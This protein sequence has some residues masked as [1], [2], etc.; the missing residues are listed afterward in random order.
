MSFNILNQ[1]AFCQGKTHDHGRVLL[2]WEFCKKS[3]KQCLIENLGGTPSSMWGFKIRTVKVL[4][5]ISYPT[6]YIMP[7]YTSSFASFHMHGESEFG[8]LRYWQMEFL[9]FFMLE[10]TLTHFWILR[11]ILLL[12]YQQK[13]NKCWNIPFLENDN[14]MSFRSNMSMNNETENSIFSIL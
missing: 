4:V 2:Q 6:T 9:I 13:W 8:F 11:L 5:I 10:N 12:G 1:N 14:S 7:K 3:Y